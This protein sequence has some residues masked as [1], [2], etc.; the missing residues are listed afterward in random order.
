MSWI[1][2]VEGEL[3]EL[4]TFSHSSP[5]HIYMDATLGDEFSAHVRFAQTCSIF[6]VKGSRVFSK[7]PPGST[8]Y[9]QNFVRSI[10][11]GLFTFFFSQ[12]KAT[13][14]LSKVGIGVWRNGCLSLFPILLRVAAGQVSVRSLATSPA[15]IYRMYAFKLSYDVLWPGRFIRKLHIFRPWN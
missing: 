8:P 13:E 4:F 14:A 9:P 6:N 15:L 7:Q 11:S 2:S 12:D 5:V 10:F 1:S 3:S